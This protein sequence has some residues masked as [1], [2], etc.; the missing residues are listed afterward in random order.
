MPG[1]RVAQHQE[2]SPALSS[3][4]DVK[5]DQN[6]RRSAH[7]FFVASLMLRLSS[8]SRLSRPAYDRRCGFTWHNDI[9]EVSPWQIEDFT[10]A[11]CR[12]K[13]VDGKT[14]LRKYSLQA[15]R[16]QLSWSSRHA[17]QSYL[18]KTYWRNVDIMGSLHRNY[19]LPIK[20]S[21]TS[22]RFV[23]AFR[24]CSIAIHNALISAKTDR[25]RNLN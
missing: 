5:G 23:F 8:L 25:S 18:H 21:T 3:P 17:V 10:K 15:G 4:P 7:E 12:P 16:V 1:P 22:F 2:E 19:C 20:T 11:L 24:T 9:V 14:Q 6:A 13:L